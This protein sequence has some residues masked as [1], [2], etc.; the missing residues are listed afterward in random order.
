LKFWS[1][2]LVDIS[3]SHLPVKQ[4]WRKS[5]VW[6]CDSIFENIKCFCFVWGVS[7]NFATDFLK[8]PLLGSL[9]NFVLSFAKK[10]SFYFSV[11]PW[12]LLQT[13][14]VKLL[15]SATTMRFQ[16][17]ANYVFHKIY[18]YHLE[19]QANPKKNGTKK[20]M[21]F[22]ASMVETG[23]SHDFFFKFSLW[24]FEV[25]EVE[26][27][28]MLNF[29]AA[30]SKFCNHFWKFGPSPRKGKVDLYDKRFRSSDLFDFAIHLVPA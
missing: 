18:V 21:L 23:L 8:A 25:V 9:M 13:S 27:R 15:I 22:L 2:G 26:W 4:I 16:M 12:P 11:W 14:E 29:E 28:S 10:D 5:T 3:L 7:L 1:F 24:P 19:V 20:P 6:K 30:T 17:L